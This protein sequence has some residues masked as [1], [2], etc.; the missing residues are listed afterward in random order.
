MDR[1]ACVDLHAPQPPIN[2]VQEEVLRR[3]R[4]FSPRIEKV[5]D[6]FAFRLDASGVAP[7]FPSV[8]A[9]AFALREDAARMGFSTPSVVVGFTRF[10]VAATARC[11][12]GVTVFEQLEAERAALEKVKVASLG[13]PE[14]VL[15]CLKRLD[16]RTL[17]ELAALPEAG[18]LERF[19]P[20]VREIHRHAS[21]I[22]W[23]PLQ[24]L[25]PE[26]PIVAE[27]LLDEPETDTTR[28]AFLAR[29]L[30]VSLI[31]ESARGYRAIESLEMTLFL[32]HAPLRMEHIKPAAPTLDTVQLADLLRLNLEGLDHQTG[33]TGML[34]R[35]HTLPIS[36]EQLELFEQKPR[37]DPASAGRALARLRAEFGP[38]AVVRAELREGHLPEACFAFVPVDNLGKKSTEKRNPVPLSAETSAD[39]HILV[40]RIYAP[41]LPLQ[42]RPVVGP[43]GCH[44]L[45]MGDAPAV[46]MKGP[47][48]LSGGWWRTEIHRDYYYAQTKE[49]RVLWVYFDQKRRRWFLHGEVE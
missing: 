35:A 38:D 14:K 29:R 5:P 36:K 20:Q 46:K 3:L 28:L 6:R 27:R 9:W 22:L 12:Y 49:G 24:P 37:R 43:G 17:Q 1:P 32:D 25:A 23:D 34:I 41:P 2:A 47:Y 21:Q 7:L 33:V 26:I 4:S 40:R 45:G 19:G 39:T 10:A 42:T 8:T 30:L 16:V 18:L 48:T 15:H 11:T 31:A 13:L 44:F